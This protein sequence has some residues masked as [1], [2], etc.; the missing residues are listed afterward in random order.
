MEL[1]QDINHQVAY[2]QGLVE[3]Y[4][5]RDAHETRIMQGIVA[6][7]AGVAE[8]LADLHA[9][10]SQLDEDLSAVEEEAGLGE[11]GYVET[12]C[13]HCREEVRFGQ[14]YL[15]EEG[16]EVTCPHCGGVVYAVAEDAKNPAQAKNGKAAQA[17]N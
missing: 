5:G 4:Q 2:L 11:E 13:P 6:V 12:T 17:Q 9:Y 16:V 3:G 7:L 14:S 8:N 1:E 10:I 15:T